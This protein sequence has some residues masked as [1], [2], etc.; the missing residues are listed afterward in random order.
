[1]DGR[2]EFIHWRDV[3]WGVHPP[4][5]GRCDSIQQ[6]TAWCVNKMFGTDCGSAT[7]FVGSHLQYWCI[8]NGFPRSGKLRS[9]AAGC[10]VDKLTVCGEFRREAKRHIPLLQFVAH[11]SLI[12]IHD[13]PFRNSELMTKTR[14]VLDHL[15]TWTLCTFKWVLHLTVHC[16]TVQQTV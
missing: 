14:N 12:K 16:S 8:A 10:G 4:K 13:L 7:Y 1:M 9:A 5:H 11:C 2:L 3:V 15:F 6:H